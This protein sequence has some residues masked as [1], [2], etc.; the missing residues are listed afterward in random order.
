MKMRHWSGALPAKTMRRA[1][2][3]G[4]SMKDAP[5]VRVLHR[6]RRP[7]TFQDGGLGPIGAEIE[8]EVAVLIGLP[9]RRKPVCELVIGRRIGLHIEGERAVGAVFQVLVLAADGVAADRV[10]REEM[11]LVVE[12]QRPEAVDRRRQ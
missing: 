5:L 12:R 2:R 6:R 10:R 1:W 4:K 8:R 9:G 3:A 7:G 11:V